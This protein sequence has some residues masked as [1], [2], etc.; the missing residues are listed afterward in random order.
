MN[1]DVTLPELKSVRKRN[2]PKSV[3][4]VGDH[5]LDGATMEEFA[6]GLSVEL[7]STIRRKLAIVGPKDLHR[8]GG[9]DS[10]AR[11]HPRQP[12]VAVLTRESP[13]EARAFNTKLG[14][15]VYSVCNGAASGG[16]IAGA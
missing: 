7:P 10:I 8:H 1:S 11:L 4:N 2:P 3:P 15:P 5:E 14:G 9:N 13:S 12:N 6:D 16:M